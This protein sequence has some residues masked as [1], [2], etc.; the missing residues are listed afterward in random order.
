M[1]KIS[2]TNGVYTKNTTTYSMD[3]VTKTCD[4]RGYNRGVRL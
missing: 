1:V 3:R 4:R 2:E